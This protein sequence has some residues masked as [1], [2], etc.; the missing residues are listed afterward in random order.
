MPTY[1]DR[2]REIIKDNPEAQTA[3]E[4]YQYGDR[5]EP[6]NRAIRAELEKEQG[7]NKKVKKIVIISDM[8]CGHRVGLT[9]RMG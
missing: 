1:A 5:S 8:H 2:A 6:Q 3:A 7:R 9:P 4:L